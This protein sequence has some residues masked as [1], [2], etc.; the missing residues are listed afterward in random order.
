MYWEMHTPRPKRLPQG[1]REGRWVQNPC[2]PS[3]SLGVHFPIHRSSQ[4]A[5]VH[6]V[7]IWII[8]GAFSVGGCDC[9]PDIR[10]SS[11]STNIVPGPVFPNTL[12]REQ[13]VDEEYPIWGP[14]LLTTCS[15]FENLRT[16]TSL[17]V[18]WWRWRW[19]WLK[20]G[21]YFGDTLLLRF[22]HRLWSSFD[23]HNTPL[24]TGRR[25]YKKSK[26]SWCA[27]SKD[28]IQHNRIISSPKSE[29][30]LLYNVHCTWWE[31]RWQLI[32]SKKVT[33]GYYKSNVANQWHNSWNVV[34]WQL[35]HK[36]TWSKW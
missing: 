28:S 16:P 12:P 27:I 36:S 8:A 24:L 17:K 4:T 3:R 23:T 21:K 1:T 20:K 6:I 25:T 31:K 13:G 33:A 9:V 5:N 10:I 35:I 34:M 29:S 30:V 11:V 32:K 7:P 15:T 2:P 14:K 22:V 18:Y 19:K 26:N